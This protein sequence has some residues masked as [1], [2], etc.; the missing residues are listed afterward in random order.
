MRLR[1]LSVFAVKVLS[2]IK[3]FSPLRRQERKGRQTCVFRVEVKGLGR[4]KAFSP[5]RRQERKERQESRTSIMLLS[6]LSVFAVK[7]LSFEN[8]SFRQE[9]QGRQ[10]KKR[11]PR[12]ICLFLT[13]S[14]SGFPPTR[15]WRKRGGL[16]LP[17]LGH[18]RVCRG[19]VFLLLVFTDSPLFSC[20]FAV[21]VL[22]FASKSELVG[23]F[24]RIRLKTY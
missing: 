21:K 13:A 14:I 7:V 11:D 2:F 3:S 8:H 18:L 22:S 24:C 17:R 4:I 5:L 6:E 20:L 12:F 19:L 23:I 16:P 1:E 15:E 9:R 10:V